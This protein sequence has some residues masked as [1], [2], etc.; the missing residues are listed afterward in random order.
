QEQPFLYKMV[1]AVRD[2][3]KDAYPELVESA[4][5]VAH[6]IEIEETRFA[7]T[8]S[9]GLK[10]L[11]EDLS[12]LVAAKQEHPEARATYSGEKA[13]KLYDTFGLPLDFMVDAARD[14]GIAFDHAG[15]DRSMTEQR[16]RAG[17]VEGRH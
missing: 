4:E 5:R 1:A 10:R 17:F 12:P 11:D 2:E 9:E 8:L 3:M 6:V 15:F 16:A 14:A 7:R 13:F